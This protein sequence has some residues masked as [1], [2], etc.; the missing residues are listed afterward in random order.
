[1]PGLLVV[2]LASAAEYIEGLAHAPRIGI[3]GGDE[4][5]H[6]FVQVVLEVALECGD[7]GLRALQ[8]F[9]H[10]YRGVLRRR[11]LQRIA[12]KSGRRPGVSRCVVNVAFNDEGAR[13]SGFVRNR[14]LRRALRARQVAQVS[15]G[16]RQHPPDRGVVGT[17]SN[18]LR[19]GLARLAGTALA[20]GGDGAAQQLLLT[21][22][23][24]G[25]Y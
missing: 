3:A 2:H 25:H 1:M 12:I 5:L 7:P 16:H 24:W 10:F 17:Q 9:A 23:G 20:Q 21:F 4:G 19:G 14:T 8:F 11:K 22:G 6:G 13:I 18:G 15:T